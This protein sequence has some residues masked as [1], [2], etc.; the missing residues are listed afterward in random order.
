MANEDEGVLISRGGAR[1]IKRVVDRFDGSPPAGRPG[2]SGSAP[3]NPG[4]QRARVT[5]A[6]PTG[7]ESAPS[8]GGK[9]RLKVKNASGTWGDGEEV[10][11]FNDFTFSPSIPVGRMVKVGWIAGGWWLVSASCS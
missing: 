4:I 5:T 7:T 1:R 9:V 8:S 3:Y 6:I 2:P 11:V 10:Q